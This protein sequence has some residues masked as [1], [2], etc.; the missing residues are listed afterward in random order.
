MFKVMRY[1]QSVRHRFSLEGGFE[2]SKE[3]GFMDGEELPIFYSTK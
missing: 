1:C 3:G 2:Q